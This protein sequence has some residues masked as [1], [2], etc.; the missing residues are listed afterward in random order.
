MFLSL[1][2]RIKPDIEK[3]RVNAMEPYA[4]RLPHLA[5]QAKPAHQTHTED[6]PGMGPDA[7]GRCRWDH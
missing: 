6:L 1:N 3:E 7:V 5:T 2:D 4:A